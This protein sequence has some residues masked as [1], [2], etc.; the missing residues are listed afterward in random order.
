MCGPECA[1]IGSLKVV[2]N[3]SRKVMVSKF[4]DVAKWAATT[5]PPTT[6]LQLRDIFTTFGNMD[7]DEKFKEFQ[8]IA[9]H[10]VF[11]G[12]VTEGHVLV[13]PPG[14]IV[15][16]KPSNKTE[17]AGLRMLALPCAID[18]SYLA[19]L[20]LL[21]PNKSAVKANTSEAFIVKICDALGS[22]L[23]NAPKR[24]APAVNDVKTEVMKTEKKR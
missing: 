5:K 11:S 17:T 13:I 9:D 7:S 18:S 3:G 21:V 20:R 22:D 12:D 19:M 10:L 14:W 8:S 24:P 2:M 15:A 6:V 16:G 1:F 4:A 23:P